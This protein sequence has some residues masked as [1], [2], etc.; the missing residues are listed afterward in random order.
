MVISVNGTQIIA[1]SASLYQPQL[2]QLAE[3]FE[4]QTIPF[5]KSA[6]LEIE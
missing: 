2:D 5:M 3:I 6:A 4:G 1:F